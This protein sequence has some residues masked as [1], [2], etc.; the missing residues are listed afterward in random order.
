MWIQLRPGSAWKKGEINAS[1]DER[2]YLVE[3]PG[4]RCYVRNRRFLR[5]LVAGSSPP[6]VLPAAPARGEVPAQP[7]AVVAPDNAGLRRSRLTASLVP[8]NTA[9]ASVETSPN[10]AF[11]RLCG[12][13]GPSCAAFQSAGLLGEQRATSPRPWWPPIDMNFLLT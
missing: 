7:E 13:P 9:R 10:P 11:K 12:L 5:P 3:V 6:V 8:E 4:G 1:K 2:T